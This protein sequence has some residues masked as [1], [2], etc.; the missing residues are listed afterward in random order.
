MFFIV[1]GFFYFLED[2][3]EKTNDINLKENSNDLEHFEHI[4]GDPTHI[5]RIDILE[6]YKP[7]LY[8]PLENTFCDVTA[9]LSCDTNIFPHIFVQGETFDNRPFVKNFGYKFNGKNMISVQ[10]KENLPSGKEARTFIFA[11]N[12]IDRPTDERPMFFSLMDKESLISVMMVLQIITNHLEFFGE[13]LNLM[14]QLMINSK[15]KV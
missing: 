4:I 14:K 8:L 3:K 11:V 9:G 12:P 13:N 10:T 6:N 2:I 1:I 5:E 7:D 15:G